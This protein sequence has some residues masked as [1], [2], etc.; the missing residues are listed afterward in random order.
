MHNDKHTKADPHDHHDRL[1][2]D[3]L[4]NA[5]DPDSFRDPLEVQMEK[6]KST[7]EAN[8]AKREDGDKDHKS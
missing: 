4:N 6:I 3:V 5:Q 8:K 2:K 1:P 7:E